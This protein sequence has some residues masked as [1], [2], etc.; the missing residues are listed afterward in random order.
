[1]MRIPEPSEGGSKETESGKDITMAKPDERH[2]E[3]LK[4]KFSSSGDGGSGRGG[5]GCSIQTLGIGD[6]VGSAVY[7]E[8]YCVHRGGEPVQM[9]VGWGAHSGDQSPPAE[10]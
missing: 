6:P 9:M 5:V 4:I 1:M 8:E 7:L 3:L 2:N 10:R